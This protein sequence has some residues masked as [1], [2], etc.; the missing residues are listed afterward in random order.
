MTYPIDTRSPLTLT[1]VALCGQAVSAALVADVALVDR[2]RS[3]GS[4]EMGPMQVIIDRR[5]GALLE[6]GRTYPMSGVGS[7][8]RCL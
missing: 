7:G 3:A 1:V 6:A 8:R 5:L 2:S 4:E